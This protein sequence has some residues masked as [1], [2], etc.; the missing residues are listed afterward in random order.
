MFVG[1]HSLI[2]FNSQTKVLVTKIKLLGIYESC[3]IRKLER[4]WFETVYWKC[5]RCFE[6][7]FGERTW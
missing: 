1:N 5:G 6:E 3:L 7:A 4:G 2:S